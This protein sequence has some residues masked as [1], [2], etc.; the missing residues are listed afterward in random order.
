MPACR[1]RNYSACH[2]VAQ[3]CWDFPTGATGGRM[4]HSRV[5]FAI[6]AGQGERIPHELV[7]RSREKARVRQSD[8]EE[9]QRQQL[10]MSRRVGKLVS[11]WPQLRLA[12]YLLA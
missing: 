6:I 1:G 3:P 10:S 12:G 8:V 7:N 5:G 4:A 11:E 2:L 9:E